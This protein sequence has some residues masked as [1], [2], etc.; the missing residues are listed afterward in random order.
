M[1]FQMVS[2]CSVVNNV[3]PFPVSINLLQPVC[4]QSGTIS[5]SAVQSNL[6]L[7]RWWGKKTLF[8]FL[9]LTRLLYTLHHH[10]WCWLTGLI[11]TSWS[12]TFELLNRP[13]S[14]WYLGVLVKGKLSVVG[15]GNILFLTVKG[16]ELGN[17]CLLR[18][19][20]LASTYLTGYKVYCCVE[21]GV[22]WCWT[23]FF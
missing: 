9:L 7:D 12:R 14:D 1:E 13:A 20:V 16:V 6:P 5:C 10:W 11:M 18:G 8:F 23:Q 17:E 19:F 21:M 3:F 15:K 22:V 4:V 2:I